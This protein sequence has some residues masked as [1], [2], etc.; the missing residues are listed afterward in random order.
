MD[1]LHSEPSPDDSGSSNE[2]NPFL[3]LFKILCPGRRPKDGMCLQMAE[4][5]PDPRTIKTHL[6]FSLLP[7]SML[8]TSKVRIRL[9]AHE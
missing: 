2:G 8:D 7:S 5:T 6:P 1:S 3:E 9:G 4:C